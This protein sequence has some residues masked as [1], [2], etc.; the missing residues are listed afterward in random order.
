MPIEW[1]QSG[2]GLYLCS[3]ERDQL[4]EWALKALRPG[5]DRATQEHG[6]FVTRDEN[7]KELMFQRTDLRQAIL[8]E[9]EAAFGILIPNEHK[10]MINSIQNLVDWFLQRVEIARPMPTFAIPQAVDLFLETYSAERAKKTEQADKWKLEYKEQT[11][12]PVLHGYDWSLEKDQEPHAW[13]RLYVKQQAAKMLEEE[14]K[15]V[16]AE[17]EKV[18]RERRKQESLKALAAKKAKAMAMKAAM[19]AEKAK[20]LEQ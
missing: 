12:N 19:E 13:M 2:L 3:L 5:V 7:F 14:R 15:R 16:Q 6:N 8:K 18:E 9:A 11:Y 10:R 20:K 17:K 4:E 1:W